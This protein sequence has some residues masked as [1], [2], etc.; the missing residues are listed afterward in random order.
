M[1]DLKKTVKYNVIFSLEAGKATPAPPVGPVLGPSGINLNDF[2]K[3]FN[4]WSKNYD[5]VTTIG[6]LAFDD[7]SFDILTKKEYLEY[8]KSV[9]NSSLSSFYHK[10][11]DEKA[12]TSR[13]SL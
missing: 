3:R 12:Q 5:G 2:C 7:G 8:K 13:K 10:W 9:L 6:V 11:E 4:E 1:S